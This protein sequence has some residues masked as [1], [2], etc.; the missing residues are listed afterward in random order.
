MRHFIKLACWLVRNLARKGSQQKSFSHSLVASRY[1]NGL[2][3]HNA[4]YLIKCRLYGAGL[5]SNEIGFAGLN[6]RKIQKIMGTRL[7]I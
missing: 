2:V 4:T 5:M 1:Q 3:P 7:H 6:L